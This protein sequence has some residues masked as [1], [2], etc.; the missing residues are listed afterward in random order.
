[1]GKPLEGYI[2]HKYDVNENNERSAKKDGQALMKYQ[3]F[4]HLVL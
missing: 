4:A 3:C 1:M 2:I